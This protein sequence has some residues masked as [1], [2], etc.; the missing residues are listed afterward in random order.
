M[1]SSAFRVANYSTSICNIAGAN[2]EIGVDRSEDRLT[3]MSVQVN[4]VERARNKPFNK[5]LQ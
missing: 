3:V 4:R 1:L 2:N 5:K